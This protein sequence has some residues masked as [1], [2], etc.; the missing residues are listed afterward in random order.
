MVDDDDWGP[1]WRSDIA[2]HGYK[3]KQPIGFL[4]EL[5]AHN[6]WKRRNPPKTKTKRSPTPMTDLF[7]RLQKESK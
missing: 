7:T 3:T 4:W 6:E 1:T 5:H 2:V